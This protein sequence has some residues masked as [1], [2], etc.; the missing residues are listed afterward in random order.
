LDEG[1][2]VRIPR[3]DVKGVNSKS[4]LPNIPRH[5][6]FLLEVVAEECDLGFVIFCKVP[7]GK[8]GKPGIYA[9]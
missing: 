6:Q 3:V 5:D 4:P 9:W 7:I 1:F 2:N 8:H